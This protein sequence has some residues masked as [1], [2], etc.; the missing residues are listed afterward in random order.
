MIHI[1][2]EAWRR[3]ARCATIPQTNDFFPIGRK[4]PKIALDACS[5]C[6]VRKQCL[7]YALDNDI[8]HGIWG[9]K[10]ESQRK[11]M[12]RRKTKAVA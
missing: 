10:T 1:P 11:R 3:K 4:S 12:K 9:G 7:Q 5:I 8:E 6:F 2:G